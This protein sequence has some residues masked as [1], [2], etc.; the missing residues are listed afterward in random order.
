MKPSAFLVTSSF[1][2]GGLGLLVALAAN[3]FSNGAGPP[4]RPMF[5]MVGLTMIG[6]ATGFFIARQ[7][8]KWDRDYAEAKEPKKSLARQ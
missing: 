3:H 8:L 7:G 6:V 5:L 1:S 4:D 2:F